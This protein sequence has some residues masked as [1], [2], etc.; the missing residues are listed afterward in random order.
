[1]PQSKAEQLRLRAIEAL[2]KAA[3]MTEPICRD[4]M[5]EV[6][7]HYTQLADDAEEREAASP[8]G[9]TSLNDC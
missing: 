3:E 9:D 1:M 8:S 6:A 7:A 5:I 4:A 2:T